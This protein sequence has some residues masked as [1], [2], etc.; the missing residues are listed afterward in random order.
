MMYYPATSDGSE[1]VTVHSGMPNPS[2]GVLDSSQVEWTK[3]GEVTRSP[4]FAPQSRWPL[5]YNGTSIHTWVYANNYQQTSIGTVRPDGSLGIHSY[6]T[7]SS[8]TFVDSLSGEYQPWYDYATT[9]IDVLRTSEFDI[10][11]REAEQATAG[12]DGRAI[13]MYLPKPHAIAANVGYPLAISDDGETLVVIESTP[14]PATRFWRTH[15]TRARL[16]VVRAVRQP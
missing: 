6:P 4:V 9:A 2:S 13:P 3:D 1:Y 15:L 11:Q 12:A 8:P 5:R 10:S 16:V 14:R 7:T